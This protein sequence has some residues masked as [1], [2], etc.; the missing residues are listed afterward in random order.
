[1]VCTLIDNDTRHHSG[2]NVV[3]SQGAAQWV[4]NKFW[5]LWRR[6]INVKE[7]QV[8]AEKGIEWHTEVSNVVWTPINNSKL[9]NQ[10]ARLVAIVVESILYSMV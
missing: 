9:A 4:H 5:A 2:P 3:D 8:R 6:N 7:N 10:I 1:M